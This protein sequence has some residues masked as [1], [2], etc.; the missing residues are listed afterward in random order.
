MSELEN[1]VRVLFHGFPVYTDYTES[2]RL[3]CEFLA[4][5]YTKA[6]NEELR[7]LL[8]GSFREGY[9][10]LI[11]SDADFMVVINPAEEI[12]T[13]ESQS[14]IMQPVAEAPAHVKL[15]IPRA[16]SELF[17]EKYYTL[18]T[19]LDLLEKDDEGVLFISAGRT[20]EVH[21][22]DFRHEFMADE[23]PS[24][25]W[26]AS[27]TTA[28]GKASP[29]YTFITS[30]AKENRCEVDRVAAIECMGWPIEAS[31]WITRQPRN[32]P[33]TDLVKSISASGFIIVPKPSD[34]S[35]DTRK[36]WRLSFSEPEAKLFDSFSA[37][38]AKVYYLLRSLY[39]RHLKGKLQGA[40][41]SYHLKTVMFWM[42]EEEKHSVWFEESTL[43]M[44]F[45]VLRK[46]LRFTK[47][48]FCPHYFIHKH[49]LF[50]KTSKSA[51]EDTV[52]EI[53]HVL[54][55]PLAVF[56]N[57]VNDEFLGLIPRLGILLV[58]V[59]GKLNRKIL[60]LPS[61]LAH[62]AITSPEVPEFVSKL[63][64]ECLSKTLEETVLSI[65]EFLH[66]AT[67]IEVYITAILQGHQ[68]AF[69][70]GKTEAERAKIMS[71]SVWEDFF[72]ME[73]EQVNQSL[74]VWLM[75]GKITVD[76]ARQGRNT[77]LFA[78]FHK[79]G[80]LLR[81]LTGPLSNDDKQTLDTVEAIFSMAG[82]FL[83]S[84]NFNATGISYQDLHELLCSILP[85]HGRGPRSW[86]TGDI[87]PV[88]FVLGGATSKVAKDLSN[89]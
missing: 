80:A 68:F 71:N 34:I 65:K 33:T 78:L 67:L 44:Y 53:S 77:E 39:V 84:V 70:M 3:S 50:Y 58:D 25:P 47:E 12:L 36:E 42:L 75:L 35:G 61:H 73:M 62:T 28:D 32:W 55:D 9:P 1:L 14:K 6:S 74:L 5:F 17:K 81:H 37:C 64:L 11:R 46:L 79:L 26:T 27:E 19:F 2:E 86:P 24:T 8:T 43:D 38:Q 16:Y 63:E 85:S 87:T 82:G 21:E 59:K 22:R 51:L 40:L 4:N 66:S 10:G 41:T 29:A 57:I 60:S 52:R 69:T 13:L 7:Y 88:L 89:I 45:R 49:N 30:L 48:G 15:I 31:E 76:S 72:E 23:K 20:R 56:G 83:A 18:S 54:S